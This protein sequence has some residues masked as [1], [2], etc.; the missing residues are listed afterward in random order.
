MYIFITSIMTQFLKVSQK[1]GNFHT[2]ISIT[3]KLK[4][5]VLVPT[6][7]SA[8]IWTFSCAAICCLWRLQPPLSVIW[9]WCDVQ[10]VNSQKGK[11]KKKIK[12]SREEYRLRYFFTFR[13]HKIFLKALNCIVSLRKGPVAEF[14]IKR[15]WFT[16]HLAICWASFTQPCCIW[17]WALGTKLVRAGATQTSVVWNMLSLTNFPCFISCLSSQSTVSFLHK[18][19]VP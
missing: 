19:I 1:G 6:P 11:K 7:I 4:G 8:V 12:N 13:C 17:G 10:R 16:L 14:I 3:T 18:W 2:H 9:T 15:C 5:D